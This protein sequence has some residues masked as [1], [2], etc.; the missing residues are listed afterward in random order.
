MVCRKSTVSL[1]VIGIEFEDTDS[2]SSPCSGYFLVIGLPL[3]WVSVQA[4]GPISR[5]MRDAPSD[6]GRRPLR[7]LPHFIGVLEVI[8][9]VSFFSFFLFGN[10][11]QEIYCAFIGN[12]RLIF[13]FISQSPQEIFTPAHRPA[14]LK[15]LPGNRLT[16]VLG[17]SAGCL[18]DFPGDAR[19]E[20]GPSPP[21]TFVGVLEVV[22]EVLFSL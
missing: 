11:L 9:D 7:P 4:G 6:D 13:T 3:P 16:M 10:G 15:I 1:V 22:R 18:A 12:C 5:E 19:S 17:L 14:S 20:E 2:G 8:R 21:P